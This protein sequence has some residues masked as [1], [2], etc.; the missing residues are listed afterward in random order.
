MHD[1]ALHDKNYQVVLHSHDYAANQVKLRK[2]STGAIYA[3][4]YTSALIWET[5]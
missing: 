3:A 5:K 1:T 4:G 2:F